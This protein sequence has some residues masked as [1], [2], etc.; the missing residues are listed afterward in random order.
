MTTSRPHP[1]TAALAGV[2]VVVL[3]ALAMRPVGHAEPP[4][5]AERGRA[6]FA[7][8]QCD[9]CH[10]AGGGAGFGPGIDD[11]RRP[12]GRLELVGRLWNHV[13]AMW[14]TVREQ[15]LRWPDINVGEMADLMTYLL[16]DDARDARSDPAKGQVVLMRKGCLKCHSYRREG[17]GIQPDLAVPR[18]D[19]ASSTAWAV[20]M[21]THTPRMVSASTVFRVPYPRFSGDEMAN[22]VGFLRSAG[23]SPP[24]GPNV[25]R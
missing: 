5:D 23:V 1:L 11:L 7:A 10:V 14:T 8:K 16:A 13:P 15:G 25:P 2:L 21:W 19:Y 3:A 12:Q 4:A 17:G 9:R 22:L 24:A 20:T 6:L 18:P